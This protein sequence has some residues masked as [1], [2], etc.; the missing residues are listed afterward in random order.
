MAL[1]LIVGCVEDL[2]GAAAEAVGIA[3]R[4]QRAMAHGGLVTVAVG[5]ATRSDRTSGKLV[6]GAACGKGRA[7]RNQQ[8]EW[9]SPRG[10]TTN[11]QK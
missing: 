5:D 8:G 11:L 7:K 2:H 3:N 1:M 4:N 10:Q 9:E 6:M